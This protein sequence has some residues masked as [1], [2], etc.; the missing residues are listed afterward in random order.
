MNLPLF[1]LLLVSLYMVG[2]ISVLEVGSDKIFVSS[3]VGTS[4]NVAAAYSAL[5]TTFF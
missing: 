5:L 3:I 4:S 2:E 1:L